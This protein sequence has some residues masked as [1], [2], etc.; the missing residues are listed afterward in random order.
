[1]GFVFGESVC[2]VPIFLGN[3]GHRFFCAVEGGEV[4]RERKDRIDMEDVDLI[5]RANVAG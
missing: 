3:L 1:V 2:Q 4:F 5:V